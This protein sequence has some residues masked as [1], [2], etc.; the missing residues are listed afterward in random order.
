MADPC[1]D[2]ALFDHL[3][4]MYVCVSV[5]KCVCDT[6]THTHTHKHTHIPVAHGTLPLLTPSN[7]VMYVVV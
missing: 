2:V 3:L 5:S 6:Q 1:E 7:P 4:H